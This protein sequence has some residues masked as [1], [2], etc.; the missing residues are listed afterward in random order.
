MCLYKGSFLWQR[1]NWNRVFKH[2]TLCF[3]WVFVDQPS[4]TIPCSGHAREFVFKV[5]LPLCQNK[6]TDWLHK[7]LVLV[8]LW[9]FVKCF[10]ITQ[11]SGRK[12]CWQQH[13]LSFFFFFQPHLCISSHAQWSKMKTAES[14]SDNGLWNLT[15]EDNWM[16]SHELPKDQKSVVFFVFVFVLLCLFKTGACDCGTSFVPNLQYMEGSI[17]SLWLS[18]L[19]SSAARMSIGPMERWRKKQ[20]RGKNLMYGNTSGSLRTEEC[21]FN[22]SLAP[23]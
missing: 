14:G 10:S 1:Q 19:S 20:I 5:T 4:P 22:V 15:G 7:C 18:P 16:N 8:I 17:F 12:W 6:A 21:W 23:H 3:C 2:L 11:F 13:I 9:N